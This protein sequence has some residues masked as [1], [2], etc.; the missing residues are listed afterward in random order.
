[1]KVDR[2]VV[3]AK[4]Q[5]VLDFM[6]SVYGDDSNVILNALH[7]MAARVGLTC[8]VT[9]EEYAAGMKH[10]WDHLANVINDLAE[11]PRH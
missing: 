8:G 10:H 3:H 5:Q 2:T 7:E 1:M 9:P 4:Q 6:I 11:N